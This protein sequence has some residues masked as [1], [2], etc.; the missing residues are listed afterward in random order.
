MIEEI[1]K[2]SRVK[3]IEIQRAKPSAISRELLLPGES[4]PDLTMQVQVTIWDKTSEPYFGT[5]PTFD[6]ALLQALKKMKNSL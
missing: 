4:P 3:K 1:L 6:D 5:G 2:L